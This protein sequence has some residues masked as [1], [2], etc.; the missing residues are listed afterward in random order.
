MTSSPPPFPRAGQT[1]LVR[2]D[3]H[4]QRAWEA[5][6]AV[7]DRPNEYGFRAYVRYFDDAAYRDLSVGALLALTPEEGG[8]AALIVADGP[9]LVPPELPLLVIDLV[10]ERGR[11]VRV[12]AE[13]LPSIENNLSIANMDFAEFVAAA[14]ED[15]V[16]R[17]F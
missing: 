12:V 2:T 3:F 7:V 6:R 4:D 16:F 13:E 14:D 1:P 15:G 10:R 17:G 5:L 8:P 11:T 9:A